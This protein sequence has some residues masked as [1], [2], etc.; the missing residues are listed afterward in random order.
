MTRISLN[1]AAKSYSDFVDAELQMVFKQ[2]ELE[3]VDRRVMFL[4]ATDADHDTLHR[5][6]KKR[7][8]VDA[9]LRDMLKA[10]AEKR[11]KAMADK[12]SF[13]DGDFDDE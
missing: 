8:I 4:E 13:F 10:V 1:E 12:M 6:R 9:E 11:K 7:S 2:M 3:S 5:A